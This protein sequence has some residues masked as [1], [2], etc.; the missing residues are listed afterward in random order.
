MKAIENFTQIDFFD[1]LVGI[2]SRGGRGKKLFGDDIKV[3]RDVFEKVSPDSGLPDFYFEFPLIGEPHVDLLI[4]CNLNKNFADKNLADKNPE[5]QK[6]FSWCST[7]PREKMSYGVEF[8]ISAGETERAGAYIQFR[9]NAEFIAPFFESIDEID[10][11]QSYL[12]VF[13]RMPEGWPPAYVGIF[14]GRADFPLRIGGY[15]TDEENK[16]CT[17]PAHLQRCFEQIG[18][19]DFN[20]EM[21]ARCAEIMEIAQSIDFQFDI[22]PDGSLSDVFG[23]AVSFNEVHPRRANECM[24]KGYGSLVMKK[25]ESWGG[26]DDRWKLLP[27]TARARYLPIEKNDDTVERLAFCVLFNFAKVKFKGGKARSSK[28]YLHA[29]VDELRD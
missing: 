12:D 27:G 29:K 16:L 9:Q 20:D 5:V 23:L 21:L 24:E 7:I 2:V 14:P 28:F 8:D 22:L 26:A 3:A 1:T 18:F 4:V 17:D 15:M 10:R 25:F 6:M 19:K 13:N 11:L